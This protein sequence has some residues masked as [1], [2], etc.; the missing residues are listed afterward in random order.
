MVTCPT[1]SY[2][3][4]PYPTPSHPLPTRPN[5]SNPVQPRPSPSNPVPPCPTPSYSVLPCPAFLDLGGWLRPYL[6]HL[7]HKCSCWKYCGIIVTKMFRLE[8]LRHNCYKN[9][10]VRNIVAQLLQNFRCCGDCG[11]VLG[12]ISS[13]ICAANPAMSNSIIWVNDNH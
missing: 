11:A 9:V 7:R 10:H 4:L 3:V 12:S 13:K 2:D 1:V 5:P 8:I 6:N